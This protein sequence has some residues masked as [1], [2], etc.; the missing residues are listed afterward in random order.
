MSGSARSNPY[1]SISSSSLTMI[2]LWTPT[3]A[4]WRMGWLLASMVGW[5]LV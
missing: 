2:P 5:P 1:V 3:T 4:P